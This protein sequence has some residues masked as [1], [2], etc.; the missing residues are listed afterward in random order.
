M[1]A[2]QINLLLGDII[3]I[4]APSNDTI[5]KEIFLITYIDKSQIQ[6]KNEK[7]F[8]I[9]G[10]ENNS[11]NDKTIEKISVLRRHTELGFAKQNNLIPGQWINIHFNDDVPVVITGEVLSLDEDM[12]EV[13]T[14]PGNKM[15]YIEIS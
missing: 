7:Q 9:L 13:K 2:T 3:E 1:S 6:I 15:I 14:Y 11:F 4:V 12:I 5:H 8:Q 10:L